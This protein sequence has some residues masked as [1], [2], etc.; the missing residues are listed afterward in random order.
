MNTP[1]VKGMTERG[2]DAAGS[3]SKQMTFRPLSAVTSEKLS[4]EHND[5]QKRRDNDF[6]GTNCPRNMSVSHTWEYRF[7]FRL[8][9]AKDV[10]S[11]FL[12]ALEE[13][14]LLYGPRLVGFFTPTV[15]H[16]GE[17]AW[18]VVPPQ[19]V[20]LFESS[21]ALLSLELKSDRVSSL[22]V[23]REDICGYG[24]ASF[25]LDSWMTIYF[26]GRG[27]ASAK[28]RF[29]TQSAQESKEF[30]S[31]F[32][33]WGFI[34]PDEG[35]DLGIPGLS[36]LPAGSPPQFGHFLADHP[37]F[38]QHT[39]CFL[40]PSGS[41]AKGKRCARLNRLF[42]KTSNGLLVLSD[43]YMQSASRW[44][45]EATYLAKLCLRRI[46]WIDG[47]GG[48][49]GIIRARIKGKSGV[50]EMEWPVH[51][52]YKLRAIRWTREVNAAIAADKTSV[53]RR[54]MEK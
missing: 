29:P 13:L 4:D 40:Q 8:A 27:L 17:T 28:I 53:S 19:V 26:A 44:G 6:G 15:S 45:L 2:E 42:V 5:W 3:A 51:I 24:L 38:G 12:G 14:T 41:S 35:A 32:H 49:E 31:L 50:V 21:L 10:P 52:K 20:V 22:V 43:Q 25:L 16:G 11:E 7:A 33:G 36:A 9:E 54:R 1:R 34:G 48:S 30:T 18:S 37:E 23:S 47:F 39:T 46:D